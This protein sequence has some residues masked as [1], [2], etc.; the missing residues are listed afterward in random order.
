MRS[1]AVLL[2]SLH[3]S[4]CAAWNDFIRPKYEGPAYA[5]IYLGDR[6]D[7]RLWKLD[8][9]E[10]SYGREAYAKT[11]EVWVRSVMCGR[12]DPRTNAPDLSLET[13]PL[14][15]AGM[16]AACVSITRCSPD[17]P[18]VRWN[19]VAAMWDLAMRTEVE[20]VEAALADADLPAYMK[21]DFVVRYR[22]ARQRIREIVTAQGPAWRALFLAPALVA[23]AD[24]AAADEV[25][26]PWTAKALAYVHDADAAVLDG[27]ADL[28]LVERG[29][30][31]RREYVAACREARR[32]LAGCLADGVSHP[33]TVALHR[34]AEKAGAKTLLAAEADGLRRVPLR[35]DPR[36]DERLAAQA[37]IDAARARHAE[38][39]QAKQE[40][41]SEAVIAEK[42]PT[43]PY[44]VSDMDAVIGANVPEQAF[45]VDS[46]RDV[47]AVDE[48]VRAVKRKG[49]RATILFRKDVYVGT[50]ATGCRET[51]KVDGFDEYGNVRYREVCTG[52]DRRYSD[53]RTIKPV[54]V[55]WAEVAH[56]K[57]GEVVHVVVDAKTRAG[58]VAW[59]GEKE[60]VQ[61]REWR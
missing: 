51:N 36:T 26:A 55:P 45:R 54:T 4:A 47:L 37:A 11:P 35:A 14:V 15:A 44:D 1:V 18:Q 16:V 40:G 58:H 7:C 3:L 31:L 8:G 22:A 29:L 10:Q 33:L 21:R 13:H 30:L 39:A 56:V 52:P 27:S 53:D 46:P 61:T 48:E 50:E 34:A 5:T 38:Y 19:W 28:A 32:E 49:A 43:P 59:V 17:D 57:P 41:L 24:R 9:Y 6:D 23:R 60:R 20:A 2:L 25:L 12:P 42:W